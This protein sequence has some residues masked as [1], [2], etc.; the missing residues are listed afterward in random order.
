MGLKPCAVMMTTKEKPFVPFGEASRNQADGR[1]RNA[2]DVERS[3]PRIGPCPESKRKHHRCTKGESILTPAPLGGK[4]M[5]RLADQCAG[6]KVIGAQAD[7]LHKH[8]QRGQRKCEN[9]AGIQPEAIV[10]GRERQS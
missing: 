7:V 9:G 2:F 8:V 6:V 3:T 1:D 5:S 10:G 4:P